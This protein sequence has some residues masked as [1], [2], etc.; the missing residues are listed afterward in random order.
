MK[1]WL[2]IVSVVAVLLGASTGV[3]FWMWSDTKAEL[4][5]TE[6]QLTSTE[7]DLADTQT[8]LADTEAEL[9]EIREVYPPQYFS[10]YNEL[11]DCIASHTPIDETSGYF[12][13]C[14]TLQE[15]VLA[16][17][18]IFSAFKDIDNTHIC[19]AIA[20]DSV[21]WVW[22]DGTIEWMAFR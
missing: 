14:L 3:G 12:R 15:M 2:V 18:Y 19:E 11:E 5:D 20:G 10:S 6:T 16:D 8:E 21:Y 1:T 9:T 17:G 7:A 4:A 13:A 22:P